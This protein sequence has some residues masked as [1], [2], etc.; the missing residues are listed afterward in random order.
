[1]INMWWRNG[2]RQNIEGRKETE[3]LPALLIII[4]ASKMPNM[5]YYYWIGCSNPRF[6]LSKSQP[7]KLPKYTINSM[8]YQGNWRLD[9]QVQFH[10]WLLIEYNELHLIAFHAKFNSSILHLY[11][12]KS[13]RCYLSL[14]H[15]VLNVDFQCLN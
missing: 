14:H 12:V 11:W 6:I 4:R 9:I 13:I 8:A 1:M 7:M 10:L 5:K 3:K 2:W 15:L